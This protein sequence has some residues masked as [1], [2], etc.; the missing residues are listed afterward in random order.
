MTKGKEPVDTLTALARHRL[1][2]YIYLLMKFIVT[3]KKKT[4][5]RK[6]F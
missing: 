3:T 1:V 6:C 5:F 4:I 2:D